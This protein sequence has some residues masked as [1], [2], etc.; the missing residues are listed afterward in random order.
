MKEWVSEIPK[1]LG[2]KEGHIAAVAIHIL[3]RE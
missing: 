3:V 2:E 1:T